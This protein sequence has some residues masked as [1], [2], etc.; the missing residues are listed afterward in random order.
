[1]KKVIGLCLAICLCS[2]SLCAQ[3][4]QNDNK[5]SNRVSRCEKLIQKL[6]LNEKQAVDFREI[7]QEFSE[8]LREGRKEM[9]EGKENRKEVRNKLVKIREEKNEELKKILTQDQYKQY[10][11]IMEKRM[12]QNRRINKK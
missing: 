3:R 1:M 7:H 12:R 5:K 8:K 9:N 11:E 10:Q 6:N 2:T 4:N